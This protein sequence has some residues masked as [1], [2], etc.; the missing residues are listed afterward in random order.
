MRIEEL[1]RSSSQQTYVLQ[2][3][4]TKTEG[5]EIH[6]DIYATGEAHPK[7]SGLLYTTAPHILGSL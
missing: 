1:C 6:F 7:A 5:I 3:T 2:M 4:Y